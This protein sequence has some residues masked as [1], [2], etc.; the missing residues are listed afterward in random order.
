LGFDSILW[1]PA[2]NPPHRDGDNDLAPARHRFK[3][4]E[5]AIASHPSFG[6][7][8]YEAVKQSPCYTVATVDALIQQIGLTPPIPMII[9]SDALKNLPSWYAP[10][11]LAELVC[12]LQIPRPESDLIST[13]QLNGKNM[14]LNTQ[15]VQMPMLSLSSSWIRAQIQKV[16]GDCK[17]LR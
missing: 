16:Q 13:I 3:M 9:G 6:I 8:N 15:A 5:L 11:R 14:T 4:V 7:S 1:I 12:F 2:G 10:E 17:G